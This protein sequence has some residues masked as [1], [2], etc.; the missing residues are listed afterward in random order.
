MLNS[1][2]DP[3]SPSQEKLHSVFDLDQIDHQDQ[4]AKPPN[5]TLTTNFNNTITL[6][7]PPP[8]FHPAFIIAIWISLSS[9]V[10]IYNK[11]IL[12]QLAFAYP[13]SLTTWHLVFATI[14]TRILSKSSSLLDGL[15]NSQLS[16]NTWF[17]SILPIGA[18]FSASLIFNN[19]AYLT[20]SVSFIQM[21]KAF[22]SVAVLAMSVLMG[23]EKANRRTILIVLL[24]SIGVAIASIGE[25]QFALT[26]FIA[27][28]LG[29]AFEASRLVA[30]QKLLHGMKMDPLVSL[31]YFAPV[32]AALN[33][34]LI[35]IYEGSAPFSQAL[36]TLGP[37]ILLTNASAAFALNVAV[38]F[39]IG[40]ASS[41]VLT[42]SG[43]LKDVLLVIGSVIL[44]GNSVTLIQ[45]F[46]YSLALFGLVAFKTNPEVFDEKVQKVL[47]IFSNSSS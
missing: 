23:L 3:I 33:A 40:S 7:K 42:L 2:A 26:G 44:F 46:G 37:I 18:L 45:V 5:A 41:L 31:Y 34:L 47:K 30:I 36:T 21:L 20:L 10:I 39:L 15:A 38:V 43:V 28:T 35:P 4:S 29:I 24:I 14:G 13:I 12:S 19:I 25:L 1:P 8:I 17:R 16:W 22:T 6:S 27:Q 11:Y 9:T 32:C